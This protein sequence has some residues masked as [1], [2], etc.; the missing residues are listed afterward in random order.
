MGTVSLC[1]LGERE[2][3]HATAQVTRFH[4]HNA[5]RGRGL[6]SILCGWAI[7]NAHLLGVHGDLLVGWGDVGRGRQ[8]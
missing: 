5:V 4:A 3:R 6:E 1:E 7:T 8:G 2:W